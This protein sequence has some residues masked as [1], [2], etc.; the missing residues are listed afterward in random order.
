[1]TLSLLQK[2]QIFAEASAR[3]I[4]W[5]R[6]Q[7]WAV[8][9]GE[10]YDDDNKGHM[11]GSLHYVRLALDL[12]LFVGG[13]YE[14][15]VYEGGHYIADGSHPAWRAIGAKWKSMRPE[16]AWGGDFAS[17]DSNHISIKHD[18]KA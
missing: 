15:D 3:L 11:K 6:Q 9:L 1:M 16:F 14:G 13:T 2:Q 5:I 12:N 7:G 4:V 18:S 10:G 8:T 17:G